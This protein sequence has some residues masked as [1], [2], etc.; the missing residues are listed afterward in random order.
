MVTVLN[1]IPNG[2]LNSEY[3]KSVPCVL[4]HNKTHPRTGTGESAA[5]EEGERE[6]RSGRKVQ[7]DSA[8]L[9]PKAEGGALSQGMQKPVEAGKGQKRFSSRASR[10]LTALLTPR[11]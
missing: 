8:P 6:T 2:A 3:G 9:A 4:D 11:F 1:N 7:R 5:E 10:K